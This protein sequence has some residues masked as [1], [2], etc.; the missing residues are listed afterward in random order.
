MRK[1]DLGSRQFFPYF[2]C[3]DRLLQL[4]K[5]FRFNGPEYR[6]RR[7]I[8][9]FTALDTDFIDY[10]Q[11]DVCFSLKSLCM[12]VQVVFVT[13]VYSYVEL[14]ISETLARRDPSKR[15]H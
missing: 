4:Y 10:V 11:K 3:E 12:L 6:T 7:N 2:R 8:Y 1:M 14:F 5:T 15:E 13:F 9:G